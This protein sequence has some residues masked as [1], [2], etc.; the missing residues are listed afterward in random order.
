MELM[1]YPNMFCDKPLFWIQIQIIFEGNC[2]FLLLVFIYKFVPPSIVQVLYKPAFGEFPK[3]LIFYFKMV[4]PLSFYV[5]CVC[6]CVCMCI[7][8]VVEFLHTNFL[9][10]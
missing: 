5:V 8:V 3:I 1:L 2:P 10:Y 6:V 7:V 9:F 4:L